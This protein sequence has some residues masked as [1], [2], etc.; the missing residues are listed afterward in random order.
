M[1]GFV[2][3]KKRRHTKINERVKNC[4]HNWILQHHYVVQSPITN[5]SI[6]VSFD[7]RAETQFVPKHFIKGVCQR[8]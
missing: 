6:K 3:P 1:L 5:N 7:G 4:F 2:I 8:N